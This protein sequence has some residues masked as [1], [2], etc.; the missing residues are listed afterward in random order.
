MHRVTN[1]STIEWPKIK[2]YLNRR[3]YTYGSA[4][5]SLNYNRTN[6]TENTRMDS[7]NATLHYTTYMWMIRTGTDIDKHTQ[8]HLYVYRTYIYTLVGCRIHKFWV[9]L[10]LVCVCVFWLFIPDAKSREIHIL[11][12]YRDKYWRDRID[13]EFS[14]ELPAKMG[15]L[16]WF[17][18]CN[19]YDLPISVYFDIVTVG[20][21]F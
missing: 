10:D 12:K 14:A 17:V 3:Q 8:M 20:R 21:F 11:G 9:R 4:A 1:I 2:E 6:R 19:L 7:F 15:H 5:F 18:W 13:S 16:S